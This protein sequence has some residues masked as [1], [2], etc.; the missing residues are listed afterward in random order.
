MMDVFADASGLFALLAKNDYM[1]IRAKKCFQRFARNKTRLITSSFV[2]VETIALLQSRINLE[3]A[4][5]FNSRISPL[6]TII[7]V[8]KG[9]YIQ[10]FERLMAEN[11][12]KLSLV[13]CLSF[14]IMESKN[15][16]LAFSFDQHFTESGFNLID[17]SCPL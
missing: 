1:H 12:R 3:A 11:R 6:L 5:A 16:N 7:W 8:D 9:W 10:A 15:I 13:D 14:E 2:L 17:D 4:I